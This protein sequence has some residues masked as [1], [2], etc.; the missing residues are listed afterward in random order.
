V[1]VHRRDCSVVRKMDPENQSRL[2]DVDWAERQSESRFLVDLH[3][4][5]GDRKGLLRD[6]SSVF[7]NAEI[8][9]V[10][11]NTQSDRRN[12]QASMR[13]TVE[14]CDMSQLS[15]VIDRL[16]QIPDVLD[17]RRLV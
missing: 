14:V 17:V 6:I 8:D 9:V 16:A 12:D 1:T 2:V 7:A 15:R 4:Q 5:A 3:V 13:F 11:V 10:G